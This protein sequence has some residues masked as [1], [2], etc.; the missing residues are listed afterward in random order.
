MAQKNS[1]LSAIPIRQKM[2]V[3]TTASEPVNFAGPFCPIAS[4]GI[5]LLKLLPCIR[6]AASAM[7]QRKYLL[8]LLR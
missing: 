4:H 3:V 5:F 6:L 7:G 1:T 8:R 2:L